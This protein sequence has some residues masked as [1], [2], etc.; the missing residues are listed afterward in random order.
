MPM[1][2][3]EGWNQVGAAGW[4]GAGWAEGAARRCC[5]ALRRR[6]TSSQHHPHAGDH[7][8]HP[9]AR[10]HAPLNLLSTP[11]PQVQFN[12]ADFVK[13]AYGTNYVETLRVQV[14]GGR[15][16]ARRRLRGMGGQAGGHV[17]NWRAALEAGPD[18]SEPP[19][20]PPPGAAAPSPL[21]QVHAN[22]RIRRIYFSD[23]LYTEAELPPEFKVGRCWGRGGAGG[24]GAEERWMGALWGRGV[25]AGGLLYAVPGG[26]LGSRDV[27]DAADARRR[28]GGCGGAQH[29]A[30]LPAA[31]PPLSA[32]S[33]SCP[34]P[35]RASSSSSSSSSSRRK[36]R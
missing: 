6:A 3:D 29:A 2:L 33:S 8:R 9:L 19:T 4:G 14:G 21:P 26:L 36:R 12:L 17:C 16:A 34:S 20:P 28:L 5:L 23:R 27:R 11:A 22:C 13:R 24:R 15:E 1:R 30:Q 25:L 31:P 35:A 32:R 18:L 10:P 7:A